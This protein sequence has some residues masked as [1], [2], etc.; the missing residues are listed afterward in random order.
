MFFRK[1][2]IMKK[3]LIVLFIGLFQLAAAMEAVKLTEKV[4]IWN[5]HVLFRQGAALDAKMRES[6][7]F[8]LPIEYKESLDCYLEH[9]SH[10]EGS[11]LELRQQVKMALW[12]RDMDTF[13]SLKDKISSDELGELIN[14]CCYLN[15]SQS[16]KRNV[17]IEA[18]TVSDV[19]FV[20]MLFSTR[21][22]DLFV[23]TYEQGMCRGTVT[24]PL[25]AIVNPFGGYPYPLDVL[26]AFIETPYVSG[27]KKKEFFNSKRLYGTILCEDISLI[28]H[29]EF[30]TRE[31][32]LEVMK[33]R[34]L[35]LIKSGYCDPT[36]KDRE[37]HSAEWY[38]QEIKDSEISEAM[39]QL[40]E[41][42]SW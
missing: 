40:K 3:V 26:Q 24:N 13:P 22:V 31:K 29:N 4:N 16:A 2:Q 27:E 5:C 10:L 28:Y 30:H 38:A 17:F 18:I 34:V 9:R 19:E 8:W 20:K 37:G 33:P 12:L 25:S 32:S 1:E 11:G 42:S 15:S 6:L 35:T 21:Q 7:L 36:L 14:E 41:K 39:Q 23:N